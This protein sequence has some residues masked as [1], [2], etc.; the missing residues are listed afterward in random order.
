MIS[1]EFVT[2]D[3]DDDVYYV[4]NCFND[5]VENNI[6]DDYDVG[7]ITEDL[8]K[9]KKELRDKQREEEREFQRKNR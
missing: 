6:D 9:E 4:D 2:E 5:G 3:D 8:Q 1:N 7:T